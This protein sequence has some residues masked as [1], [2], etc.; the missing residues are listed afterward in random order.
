[1]P[2]TTTCKN[3]DQP[4]AKSNYGFCSEHRKKSLTPL[5]ASIARTYLKGES[6]A[7][8]DANPKKCRDPQCPFPHS[9]THN[10]CKNQPP[11]LIGQFRVKD[12]TGRQLQCLQHAAS[13]KASND[14]NN[15]ANNEHRRTNVESNGRTKLQNDNKAP[16]NIWSPS[17]NAKTSAELLLT[18]LQSEVNAE[19]T[20]SLEEKFEEIA[21][22]TSGQN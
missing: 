14:A 9:C 15:A 10:N 16:N 17:N 1:M 3:C 7:S 19:K 18:K 5:V 20:S 4:A 21:Q 8:C 2:K 12:S 11:K 6:A 22:K 13:T